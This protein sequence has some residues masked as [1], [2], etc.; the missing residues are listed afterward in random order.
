MHINSYKSI[1]KEILKDYKIMSIVDIG[2]YFKNVRGEQIVFTI[3]KEKPGVRHN[4][5]FKK[6]INDKF[7][8]LIT[9]NQQ[10]FDNEILLFESEEE[11]RI[12]EKLNKN[13]KNLGQ[14]CTGYIGRGKSKS[15]NAISGK[16][17]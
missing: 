4:I 12:Y 17:S 1:R 2:A 13:Y 9:I 3:K 10:Y 15:E 6:L 14:I 7:V 16:T 8:S 11:I 5:E